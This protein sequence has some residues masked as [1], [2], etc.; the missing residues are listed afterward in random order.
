MGDLAEPGEI[1]RGWTHAPKG[2]LLVLCDEFD[3]ES[4]GNKLNWYKWIKAH[5]CETFLPLAERNMDPSMMLNFGNYFFMSNELEPIRLDPNDRRNI[6]IATSD[7]PK[8]R[9]SPSS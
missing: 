4:S 8:W 5:T 2:K 3:A 9:T 1:E 6:F 7:D